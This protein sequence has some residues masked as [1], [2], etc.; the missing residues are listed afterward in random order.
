MKMA[1]F[2][3]IRNDLYIDG[4]KVIKGYESYSGWY[5][6]ATEDTGTQ[7]SVFPGGREVP[8]DTIYFG[9]V[10][11]HEEEWGY[12]SKAELE[13]LKGKVWEIPKR[14]LPYSGRRG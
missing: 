7:T 12:F 10:Q 8:N 2:E 9:F 6:F 4:K 11:G 1:K 3:S 13:S 5:W 14:A